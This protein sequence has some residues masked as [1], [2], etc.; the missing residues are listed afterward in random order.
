MLGYILP[1]VCEEVVEAGALYSTFPANGQRGPETEREEE[2]STVWPDG[3]FLPCQPEKQEAQLV[4]PPLL[5]LT[6]NAEVFKEGAGERDWS[7]G[8]VEKR[9]LSISQQASCPQTGRRGH[10]RPSNWVMHSR[11]LKRALR[12]KIH[13]QTI[14]QTISALAWG[15]Q[16]VSMERTEFTPTHIQYSICVYSTSS[17]LSFSNINS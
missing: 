2:V 4:V 16:C 3:W 7:W 6:G 14:K 13:F 8:G 12:V 17:K 11:K 10:S 1:L 9:P 5:W 15:G